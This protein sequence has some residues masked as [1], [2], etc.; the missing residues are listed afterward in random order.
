MT[1]DTCCHAVAWSSVGH[2]WGRACV[3]RLTS[4]KVANQALFLKHVAVAHGF[5]PSAGVA[6]EMLRMDA[7]DRGTKAIKH[8]CKS[9]FGD[10]AQSGMFKK[11]VTSP[12]GSLLWS[13]LQMFARLLYAETQ[14]V[15]GLNSLVKLQGRRC[16]NISLE[17]LSSR[18]TI[19]RMLGQVDGNN[20]CRRKFSDIKSLAEAEVTELSAFATSSLPILALESRW[21]PAPAL[22]FPLANPAAIQDVTA[23]TAGPSE[24]PEAKPMLQLCELIDRGLLPDSNVFGSG[25]FWGNAVAWARS[26]NLGYKWC[27]GGGKKPNASK[28]KQLHSNNGIGVL[29]I[30]SVDLAETH[31]Y[32]VTDRFAHSVCFSRL[33]M[34]N[35]CVK[36]GET[37]G[38]LKWEHDGSNVADTI[39][40]T[41]LFARYYHT[42][43]VDAA[44]VQVRVSF[45]T[46]ATCKQLFASPGYLL[47]SEVIASSVDA[48]T[49]T[50]ELMKGVAVANKKKPKP[51]K[52][53][54]PKANSE[55]PDDAAA[56]CE[57]D[58]D[59][60]DRR[61]GADITHVDDAEGML[62]TSDSGV[63]TD[64]AGE[65]VQDNDEAAQ[66]TTNEV[67]NSIA[68]PEDCP[69]TREVDR[70]A[71]IVAA[72]GCTQTAAE[73]QEEALLLLVR[74]R[75]QAKKNACMF[76]GVGD[77]EGAVGEGTLLQNDS[78]SGES[79]SD[80]ELCVGQPTRFLDSAPSPADASS[81]ETATMQSWAASC[82]ETLQSLYD[83]AQLQTGKHLGQ[84]RSISLVL[85]HPQRVAGCTCVRCQWGQSLGHESLSADLPELLWVTWLNNS[86]AHGLLGRRA[87]H[88]T[89]DNDDKVLYCTADTTYARTGIRGGL[90]HPE[91]VCDARH[92]QIIVPYVGAAM[93]K[94][95]KTSPDR[96]KVP[97]C[98][99]RALAFYGALAQQLSCIHDAELD[100]STRTQSALTF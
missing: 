29:I 5:L 41:L 1:C 23:T 28:V 43:R 91:I 85:M 45:L 94:V 69:P 74:Q 54:D 21:S 46:A 100:P 18:L 22:D 76:D 87:R 82:I 64:E 93:K 7:L 89:L 25:E 47:A 2:E 79:A 34:F 10:M 55:E 37:R 90:G 6:A 98:C 50:S 8:L 48:F 52:A 88:V 31:F 53:R 11:D 35:R 40:S 59:E 3:R 96:D 24:A 80:S 27:T 44:S 95:K 63:G 13:I 26:Y 60:V 66:I 39:E 49:M 86:T 33:K 73:I 62:D 14:A 75:N 15:E 36:P 97:R 68:R 71:G 30:P 83:V 19:K 56:A 16:P 70:V 17:L 57:A 92:C 77:G 42:C 84:D 61:R 58:V 99:L 4:D 67:L 12:H 81:R 78:G 38:C 65:D 32:V 72:G 20:G 9:E 51:D